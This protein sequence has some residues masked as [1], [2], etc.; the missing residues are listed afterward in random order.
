M[1]R[2]LVDA[3]YH[4][5][6]P[7][8][9]LSMPG[10]ATITRFTRSGFLGVMQSDYIVY[11]KSMGLPKHLIVYKYAFRNAIVATVTQMG[12]IMGHFLAGTVVIEYIYFWPGIGA[13][14]I[15]VI[16]ISTMMEFWD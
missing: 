10:I 11:S 2:L 15:D 12:I 3:L 4:L 6:L 14:T 7:A 9:T 16:L 8:L 5:V 13:Y 1:E